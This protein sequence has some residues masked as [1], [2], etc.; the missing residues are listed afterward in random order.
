[1]CQASLI[2]RLKEEEEEEEKGPGFSHLC[3][4]LINVLISGR[5]L[6]THSKSHGLLYDVTIHRMKPA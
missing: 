2:P 6:M 5:M 1:M 4:R 3:M